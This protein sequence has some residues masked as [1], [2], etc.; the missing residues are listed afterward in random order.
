MS[1]IEQFAS[2]SGMSYTLSRKKCAFI[3]KEWMDAGRPNLVRS[4][5]GPVFMCAVRVDEVSG[6]KCLYVHWDPLWI[7]MGGK[8][9]WPVS[10]MEKLSHTTSLA[11]AKSSGCAILICLAVIAIVAI[12]AS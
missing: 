3:W 9:L 5:L 2:Q 11:D 10:L 6:L 8:Q 7:T 1:E 4:K 12:A